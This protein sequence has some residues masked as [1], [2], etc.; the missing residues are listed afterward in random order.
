LVPKVSI[1]HSFRSRD[2]DTKPCFAHAIQLAVIDVLYKTSKTVNSQ[3]N[4]LESESE[5]EFLSESEM[6]TSRAD[7][8]KEEDEDDEF[9]IN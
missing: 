4:I 8:C 5:E 3:Q 2:F 9:Q 7:S 1:L 6:N